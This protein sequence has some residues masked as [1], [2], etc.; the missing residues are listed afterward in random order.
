VTIVTFVYIPRCDV[1]VD[2]NDLLLLSLPGSTGEG[3]ALDNSSD[4]TPV[5]KRTAV[6]AGVVAVI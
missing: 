5:S 6:A 2:S 1:S 4:I 3:M